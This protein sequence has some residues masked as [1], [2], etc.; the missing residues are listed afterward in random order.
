[1]NTNIPKARVN[2]G[3]KIHLIDK[4]AYPACSFYVVSRT[5]GLTHGSSL[6]PVPESFP[7]TCKRCLKIQERRRTSIEADAKPRVEA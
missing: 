2:R 1:M 5:G 7:I 4:N 3:D 6:R